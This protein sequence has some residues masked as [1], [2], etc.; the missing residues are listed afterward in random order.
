MWQLP[1][2]VLHAGLHTCT[3]VSLVVS[4]L[5]VQVQTMQRRGFTTSSHTM[6]LLLNVNFKSFLIL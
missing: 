3:S 5:D 4:Q 2:Q 1:D 6:C